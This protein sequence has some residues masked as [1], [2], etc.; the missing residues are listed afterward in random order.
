METKQEKGHHLP[1]EV[2]RSGV[3]ACSTSSSIP[4]GSTEFLR[5]SA[6]FIPNAFLKSFLLTQQLGNLDA[7]T[8]KHLPGVCYIG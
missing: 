5:D 8:R 2:R 6:A 1:A 7:E 4:L 3:S